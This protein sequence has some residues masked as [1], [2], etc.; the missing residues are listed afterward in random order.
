MTRLDPFAHSASWRS[1]SRYSA[2]V[3]SK[4]PFCCAL[5]YQLWCDDDGRPC[6]SSPDIDGSCIV[7][8]GSSFS[9]DVSWL[10]WHRIT[11]ALALASTLWSKT[12]PFGLSTIL[13]VHPWGDAVR[14]MVRQVARL[15]LC[16]RRRCR[17]PW[18]LR[19]SRSLLTS[20]RSDHLD[21]PLATSPPSHQAWSDPKLAWAMIR[22]YGSQAGPTQ[23]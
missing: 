23:Y 10:S 12:L 2:F 7:T 4:L 13:P 20:S 6:S 5:R 17:H 14:F 16:G 1:L 18:P 15:A 19:P 8:L 3:P 9:I 21:S 22:G 11:S